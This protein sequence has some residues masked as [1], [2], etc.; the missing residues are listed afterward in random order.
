M[1]QMILGP[2]LQ[3]NPSAVPRFR[4]REFRKLLLEKEPPVCKLMPEAKEKPVELELPETRKERVQRLKAKILC[5]LWDLAV[6]AE[7]MKPYAEALVHVV[8]HIAS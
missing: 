2:P 1:E 4:R 5:A 3:R 7:K 6:L 8:Y